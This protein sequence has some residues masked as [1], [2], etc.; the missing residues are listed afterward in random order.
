M[1]GSG[2]TNFPMKTLDT[3]TGGVE[4]HHFCEVPVS[5][6]GNVNRLVTITGVAISDVDLEPPQTDPT[7][8]STGNI[9]IITDYQLK[10][11]DKY[12]EIVNGNKELLAAT[13]VALASIAADDRGHEIPDLT[14]AVDSVSA[15]VNGANRIEIHIQAALQG[16]ATL[17]RISYQTNILI[18]KALG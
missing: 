2:M 12:K 1:K 3:N 5:G 7:D 18:Q 8:I 15:I 14:F 13:Y 10:V 6:P 9:F 16:D 4:S 11:Q 17:S